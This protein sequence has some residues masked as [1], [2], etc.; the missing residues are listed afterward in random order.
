M[1]VSFRSIKKIVIYSLVYN[2]LRKYIHKLTLTFK[3][4][5]YNL[6]TYWTIIISLFLS[7]IT[8][9]NLHCIIKKQKIFSHL[10]KENLLLPFHI[11]NIFKFY[12]FLGWKF[13]KAKR[14]L[15]RNKP[16]S[17]IEIKES[18]IFYFFLSSMSVLISA[19]LPLCHEPNLLT[20]SL[21]T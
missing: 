11:R 14:N 16:S 12:T 3:N 17:N 2:N 20:S 5:Y 21:S 18:F 4:L 9:I 8:F 1:L 7:F 15:N 13:S 19:Q 6:V 10:S